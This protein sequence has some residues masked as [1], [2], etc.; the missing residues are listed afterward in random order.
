[1]SIVTPKSQAQSNSPTVPEPPYFCHVAR[2]HETRPRQQGASWTVAP[3]RFDEVQNASR[4]ANKAE[5]RHPQLEAALA[6]CRV[7]KSR[8]CL[9]WAQVARADDPVERRGGTGV[10]APGTSASGGSFGKGSGLASGR[11]R[12]GVGEGFESGSAGLGFE[13]GGGFKMN[14]FPAAICDE[15]GASPSLPRP[16]QTY[17]SERRSITLECRRLRGVAFTWFTRKKKAGRSPPQKVFVAARQPRRKGSPVHDPL[18]RGWGDPARRW[19]DTQQ[20]LQ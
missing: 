13:F 10:G 16:A 7:R 3:A 11:T 1:M 9:R 18:I 4:K 6:H 12:S 20:R 19:G 15:P 2:I 14:D 8:L 5:P 17:H